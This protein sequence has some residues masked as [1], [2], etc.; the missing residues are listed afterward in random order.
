MT[1]GFSVSSGAP[2][3][4]QLDQFV[5][6]QL[7]LSDTT[8]VVILPRTEYDTLSLSEVTPCRNTGDV[9]V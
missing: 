9:L 1:P 2:I 6:I 3:L 4:L 8:T 5:A 7:N